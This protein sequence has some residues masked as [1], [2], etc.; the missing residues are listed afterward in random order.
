LEL[1]DE[2]FLWGCFR[3]ASLGTDQ[4]HGIMKVQS[5]CFQQANG[6]GSGATNSSCAVD[7]DSITGSDVI[8]DFLD[9]FCEG[10]RIG[11]DFEIR[12]RW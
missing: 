9:K 12:P 2:A 11:G 5:Q 7:E 10:L 6:K 1:C 8:R 3:S 4:L